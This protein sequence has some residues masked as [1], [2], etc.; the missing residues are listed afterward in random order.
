MSRIFA[1]MGS[2]ENSPIMVTPHQKIIKS[3]GNNL[4]PI[5]LNTPYGFQENI[6]ELSAKI[7]KYFEV[8][9]GTKITTSSDP[10]TDIA[11]AGWVFAGPGSPTYTLRKWRDAGI[12]KALID[13]TSRGSLVLAS[14]AAMSVG[15]KVMPVYEMYKVGEDP[16][17]VDGLNILEAATGIKAAVIAHYNNAQGGTHDTRYCFAGEKR[18]NVLESMLDPEIAIIGVDEHTGIAFDL[19]TNTVEVFG[20]GVFTYKKN[21]ETKTFAGKETFS[22][23]ELI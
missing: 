2:G 16:Y 10:L 1:L 15:A 7:E 12:D 11:S 3:T 21:G 18:M 17:W 4:N 20:K 6:D 5:N 22:I 13:L 14:A 9:V 19:D 8:N 23:S